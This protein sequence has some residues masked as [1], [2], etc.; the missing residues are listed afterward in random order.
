MSGKTPRTILLFGAAVIGLAAILSISLVSDTSGPARANHAQVEIGLDADPAG[1]TA[2]SLGTI[3]PCRS[4]TLGSFFDVDVYVK[5]VHD[6]LSWEAYLI[7]DQTVLTVTRPGDNFQGNNSR[8][9]FQQAQPGSSLYN[10]SETLP[11]TNGP[12]VYR[13]GAADQAVI[14]GLGDTGTGVLLRLEF[15]AAANGA[16]NL[17]ISPYTPPGDPEI[18]PWLKDSFGNFINDA[19]TDG[20]FDGP[21]TSASIAVGGPCTDEDG[22]GIPNASDNCPTIPN[23]GQEN[24]DSDG[25]GDACDN[26]PTVA[27][28]DQ[29]NADGDSLGDACDVGDTDGDF[30]TDQTEYYCGSPPGDV[31]KRHERLDLAGDDD[32]DTAIDEPLPAG[33]AAFDC[34][35]DGWPGNQENLIYLDAPGTARDQDACGNN[36]W[37]ADLAPPGNNTVNIQDLNSFLAPNRPDDGHGTFNKFGHPLDD[38]GDTVIDAAMARWNL[39]MPPHAASTLINIGDLNALITG[40]AGSP[41]RPPMFGGQQAFFTNGGMC[42]WPP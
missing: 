19:D 25:L 24:S 39:Q 30:L 10:T 1:N 34:D 15:Q 9:L 2:T 8:F 16:T 42:P 11:D 32:G 21:I 12:G 13:I 22:D 7:Y 28:P 18:G 38:D 3:N 23:P 20:F 35:G 31:S 4:V 27:N 17:S 26:C 29:A 41:A 33:S 6:L 14:P 40:A 5:N 37:P 36:G